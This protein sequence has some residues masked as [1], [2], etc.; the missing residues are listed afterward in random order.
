MCT[1]RASNTLSDD[2]ASSQV[3][4][5]NPKSLLEHKK[6]ISFSAKIE[7]LVDAAKSDLHN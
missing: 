7:E 3:I 1:C 4:V 5:G 6:G 2:D